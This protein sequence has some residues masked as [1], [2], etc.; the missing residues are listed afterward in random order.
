MKPKQLPIGAQELDLVDEPP[1][2]TC[3]QQ[4]SMIHV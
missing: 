2:V 4:N 3:S 1:G